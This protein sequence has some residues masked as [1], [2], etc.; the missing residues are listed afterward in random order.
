MTIKKSGEHGIPHL[1]DGYNG[2]FTAAGGLDVGV[3]CYL[4]FFFPMLVSVGGRREEEAKGGYLE[5]MVVGFLSV[6]E[7]I[8][9]YFLTDY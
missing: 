5:D 9:C 3:E 2:G 1:I 7:G 4:R 8:A 6:G